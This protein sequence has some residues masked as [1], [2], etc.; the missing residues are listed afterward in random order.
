PVSFTAVSGVN[1]S[2]GIAS[3]AGTASF[4]PATGQTSLQAS[5]IRITRV[6]DGYK[7]TG[8]AFVD[9]TAGFPSPQSENQW[10]N[11][12]SNA[13]SPWTY[14]GLTNTCVPITNT[15]CQA[16]GQTYQLE[17]RA[18]TAD[19]GWSMPSVPVQFAVDK[20]APESTAIT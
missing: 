15:N 18:R 13:T 2:T 1:Y 8:S 4:S 16:D 3:L 19:N 12:D 11:A 9:P 7:W 20:S 10:L 5:Q 17:T 6:G 14:T